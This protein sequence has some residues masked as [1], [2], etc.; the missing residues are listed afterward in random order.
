[1]GRTKDMFMEQQIITIQMTEREYLST[2]S[3]AR[4]LFPIHKREPKEIGYPDDEVW[5]KLKKESR[6]AYK[7]LKEREH[8]LRH[9]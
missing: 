3:E 6:T 9:G 5:V 8:K 7:K 1:M 2:P 4:E